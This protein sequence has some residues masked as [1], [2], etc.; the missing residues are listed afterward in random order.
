MQDGRGFRHLNHEGRAPACQVIAGPDAREDA[1]HDTQL[2]GSRRNER[3]HLR[4][5]HHERSLPKISRFAA[6]VGPGQ[7]QNVVGCAIQI[8]IVGDKPLA[9]A[10]QLLLLDHRMPALNDF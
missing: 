2:R 1:I 10:G 4:Q 7:Q 5:N 6:H 9:A 3:S 8:K